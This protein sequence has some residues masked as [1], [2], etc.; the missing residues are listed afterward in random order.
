MS[1]FK[2][3]LKVCIMF[4]AEFGD[5]SSSSLPETGAIVEEEALSE[6]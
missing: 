6:P 3:V 4:D 2:S 1:R 5:E